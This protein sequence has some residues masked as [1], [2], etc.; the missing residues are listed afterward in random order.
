MGAIGEALSAAAGVVND[1]FVE[2]YSPDKCWFRDRYVT[3]DMINTFRD[4]FYIP[5]GM[6]DEVVAILLD[7]IGANDGWN[8]DTMIAIMDRVLECSINMY[9]NNRGIELDH[10]EENFM[11]IMLGWREYCLMQGIIS[12][13]EYV[14]LYK[15]GD[16][17]RKYHIKKV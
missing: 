2:G 1:G 12:T 4:S 10:E 6:G 17:L 5:K 8:S 11:M 9:Q 3:R 14:Q 16:G 7:R 15:E 13:G